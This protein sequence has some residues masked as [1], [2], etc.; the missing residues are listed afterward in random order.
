MFTQGALKDTG[1]ANDIAITGQFVTN[2]GYRLQPEILFPEGFV[3]N[4]VSVGQTGEVTVKIFDND[5][6]VVVG[7]LEL[8]RFVNPAGLS[9]MGENIFKISSGSGEAIAG[10][11][12]RDGMGQLQGLGMVG[13]EVLLNLDY[14][15]AVQEIFLYD[16]N[17][18]KL[19]AEVDDFCDAG[20]VSLG[21]FHKKLIVV[22]TCEKIKD[23]EIVIVNVGAKAKGQFADRIQVLADNEALMK[24]L[25]PRIAQSSP[26]AI[27]I[28]TSNPV[29]AIA[30]FFA[31]YSKMPLMHII[32][33]GTLLDSARL[34]FLLSEHYGVHQSSLTAW[35]LGEHGS[36][37][38]IPW[39]LVRV[40]GM[41]S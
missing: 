20:A 32:G 39:S 10:L 30:H 23:C 37:S 1:N 3:S 9:A 41:S 27:V 31:K 5:E 7:Q 13:K 4:S 19:Q 26:N 12:G 17:V 8:Y 16:L 25:A 18:E 34:S 14:F 24:D 15:S 38:F 35:V 6:P 21:R 28:I 36:T 22:E 40:A 29:D 11:P 33:S 2:Q